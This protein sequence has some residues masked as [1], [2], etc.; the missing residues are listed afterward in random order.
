M[1]Y[2]YVVDALN[3]FSQIPGPVP[4]FDSEFL[5]CFELVIHFFLTQFSTCE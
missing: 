4:S 3:P 2:I 5:C 1:K